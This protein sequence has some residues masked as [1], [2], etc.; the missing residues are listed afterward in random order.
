MAGQRIGRVYAPVLAPGASEAH[1]K[2]SEI[3]FDEIFHGEIHD[4]A[5]A[6]QKIR[7]A[8]LL[9][10]EILYF[11][12][13]AGKRPECFIASRVEDAAAVE[14]EAASVTAVIFR[15]AFAIG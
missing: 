10:Q 9:F 11:L 15:Y 4:I 12:I 13:A 8:G 14:Y 6:V 1:R 3:P 7:H 2:A 5:G